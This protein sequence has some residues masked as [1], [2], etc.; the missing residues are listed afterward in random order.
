[1]GAQAQIQARPHPETEPRRQQAQQQAEQTLDRDAIAVIAETRNALA[2]ILKEDKTAALSALERAS[3]KANIL[4]ARNP[5]AALIPIDADVEVIDTAPSDVNTIRTPNL[6][7]L[8]AVARHDYPGARVLLDSLRSEIRVRTYNLPLDTYPAA[9]RAAARLLEQNRNK[10]A[11]DALQAALS[12]LVIVDRTLAIPLIKAQDDISAANAIR[13][14]DKASALRELGE[15]RAELKRAG[16]LGYGDKAT[17]GRLD[18]QIDSLQAKL[19]S[20]ENSK[21][22]FDRLRIAVEDFFN[23]QSAAPKRGDR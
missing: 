9:L 10:D 3:G 1:V 21:S 15:A 12:T 17:F 20:N 8:A 2:A 13:A 11:G 23:K 22:A 5:A 7:I 19:R 18:Q 14:R 6:A 4:L 16:A